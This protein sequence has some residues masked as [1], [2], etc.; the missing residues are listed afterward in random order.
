ME[1][2]LEDITKEWSTDLLIPANPVEIYDIDSLEILQDTP[3][4]S[5]TKKTDKIQD[6]SS[7]SV[8]TASM[9]P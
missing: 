9:S 8:N 4:P 7:A 1:D 3:E 2:D 6:L 5:K